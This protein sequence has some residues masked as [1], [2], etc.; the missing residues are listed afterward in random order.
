MIDYAKTPEDIAEIKKL[1]SSV[2]ELNEMPF[3][4]AR[5]LLK[6]AAYFAHWSMIYSRFRRLPW[7][8]LVFDSQFLCPNLLREYIKPEF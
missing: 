8:N 7:I 6:E 1:A 5:Q 4:E 2:D 3:S